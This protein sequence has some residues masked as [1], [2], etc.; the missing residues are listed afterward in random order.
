M[1]QTFQD[2]LSVAD[3]INGDIQLAAP[4]NIYFELKKVAADPI[5]SLTDAAFIIEKDPALSLKLLQIV[6][7]AFYGLSAEISS[8]SQAISLIG[9]KELQ[10]II[11]STV[12]V[13]KFSDLPNGLISMYDFWGKSLRNALIAREL[14]NYLGKNYAESVFICGILHHIGELVFCLRIPE[15]ARDITL[16]VQA[17]ELATANDQ[18]EVEEAVL[19][20]NHF[21]AGAEL[22]QRWKLPDLITDSIK[23]HTSEDTT[24]QHYEIAN[25]IRLASFYAE[26]DA[27]FDA[28]GIDNLGLS[29]RQITD[30]IQT[31]DE[32]F[33]EVFRLFYSG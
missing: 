12:I 16:K 26:K 1:S 22:T 3:L 11:L 24:E 13:D 32:K 10:N 8:I 7:S 30:I 27:V 31:S 29:E 5:K 23:L 17:I 18:V 33:T 20:F 25:I 9:M 14:D 2:K 15:L 6:N 28:S 4:P 19:G 21:T